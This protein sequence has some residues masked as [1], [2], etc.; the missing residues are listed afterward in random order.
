M[1]SPRP[2]KKQGPL[3]PAVGIT[4]PLKLKAQARR[5]EHRALT[6]ITR[7]LPVPR[8]DLLPALQVQYVAIASIKPAN[9]RTRR[10]EAAQDARLDRSLAKFG[11]VQP[12]LVDEDDQIAHGHGMW[13][14]A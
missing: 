2:R 7:H 5:T 8:N 3:A 11:F 10:K 13:E 14:A 12:M 4:D 6:E 9:R 1:S